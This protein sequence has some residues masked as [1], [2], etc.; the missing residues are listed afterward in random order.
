MKRYG[1]IWNIHR[2][3]SSSP[4]SIL[5]T[6]GNWIITTLY[7]KTGNQFRPGYLITGEI[8][9]SEGDRLIFNVK[10]YEV[11]TGRIIFKRNFG[12]KKEFVRLIAH[13]TSDEMMK[14]FGEKPYFHI[15]NSLCIQQGWE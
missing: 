13:R 2:C 5:L 7:L 9:I 15:K 4:D 3:L 10:V 8:E 11:S 14:H 12:A 6:S 1:T